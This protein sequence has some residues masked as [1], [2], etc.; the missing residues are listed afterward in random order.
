MKKSF[1]DEK[2]LFMKN[3]NQF[4]EFFEESIL[5]IHNQLKT[6]HLQLKTD[7]QDLKTH[8]DQILSNH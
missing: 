2:N 8:V 4:K 6:I 7:I 3:Q 5:K 1:L